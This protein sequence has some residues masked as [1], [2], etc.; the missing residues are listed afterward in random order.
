MIRSYLKKSQKIA[1]MRDK[2]AP[3]HP[4]FSRSVVKDG[5]VVPVDSYDDV[6]TDVVKNDYVGFSTY[7]EAGEQVPKMG[8]FSSAVNHLTE[9][10]VA[11]IF[12]EQFNQ[13][14]RMKQPVNPPAPAPAP[15]PAPAPAPA[16]AP[17][18]PQK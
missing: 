1:M 18:E 6:P 5:K 3:K 8:G 14:E 12:L 4:H 11:E 17:V 16:P 7:V 9:Q 10:R 2:S 13:L 15:S